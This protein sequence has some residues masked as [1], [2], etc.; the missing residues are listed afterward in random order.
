VSDA[1]TFPVAIR[2]LRGDGG[3]EG[4]LAFDDV[5]V[6]SVASRVVGVI[7]SQQAPGRVGWVWAPVV[8]EIGG[9]AVSPNR[10]RQQ[11]LGAAL[12]SLAASRCKLLQALLVPG[13]P[14]GQDFEALGFAFIAEM[15]R[16]E[17]DCTVWS[18]LAGETNDL[19]FVSY[20]AANEREF[21]SIIEQTYVGSQD[22]PE[23]DD[24][25]TVS[26]ALESYKVAG[27]FR[28]DLW[29]LARRFGE[30]VGC[31]LLASHPDDQ[32]CELQY[33]GVVPQARGQ[34]IG[35]MLCER[36]LSDAS[37]IGANKLF[38]SMDSRNRAAIRHYRAL[39]FAET[40][41]RA[42]YILTL[43]IPGLS[44]GEKV[45]HNSQSDF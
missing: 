36:A 2:L 30:W 42:V 3:S 39:E 19:E 34:R 41:R 12:E 11:L 14:R 27:T 7:V 8:G 6:A 45:M 44:G 38:L 15:I 25:R 22:C 40:D 32:T 43:P 26:E 31:V 35:R 9:L 23:L 1:T 37:R 17:R 24:L 28:P 20:E 18:G 4:D 5:I 13:D 33:M 21:E 29:L 10:I 16:M